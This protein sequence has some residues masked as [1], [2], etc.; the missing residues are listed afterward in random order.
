[1]NKTKLIK[2]LVFITIVFKFN[3][4]NAQA[5][6]FQATVR[7][8]NQN[9]LKNQEIGFKISILSD[10]NFRTLYSENH[11]LKS[12]R[13]GIATLM[14][15]K[16]KPN[17]GEFKAIFKSNNRFYLKI[18]SDLL[19]GTNYTLI[20][21][22]PIT[23]LPYALQAENGAPL[24]EIGSD[25]VL[26]FCDNQLTWVKHGCPPKVDS[27]K[28][29]TN[30]YFRTNQDNSLIINYSNGNKGYLEPTEFESINFKNIELWT[31]GQFL[32]K[33]GGEITLNFY[34]NSGINKNKKNIQFNVLIGDKKCSIS[35]NTTVDSEK[36][37]KIG[38]GVTDKFGNK[39]KTVIINEN[40]WMAENLIVSKY[41]NDS[42]HPEHINAVKSSHNYSISSICPNGWRIPSKD[43]WENLIG[44]L[45]PHAGSMLK[46]NGTTNWYSPNYANNQSLFNALPKGTLIKYTDYKKINNAFVP[47]DTTEHIGVGTHCDWWTS[48]YDYFDDHEMSKYI[49]EGIYYT[50]ISNSATD[51]NFDYTG[52]YYIYDDDPRIEHEYDK[53]YNY[54]QYEQKKLT[55]IYKTVRC[56]KNK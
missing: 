51:F 43:D 28:C 5:F 29:G 55:G 40:E 47:K 18:E 6:S 25:Q 39:Y 12:S 4:I 48:D 38:N 26:A 24:P 54:E 30:F 50:T 31:T 42:E 45:G 21:T 34:D 19:G 46:E 7:D 22:V 15:G 49:S 3:L 27:L 13:K 23:P 33:E 8:G 36:N 1:M 56:I 44:F 11:Q 35:I 2:T 10:S 14:I 20:D 41:T 52:T 17:Y 9:I 16:G 32:K 53:Y 37:G